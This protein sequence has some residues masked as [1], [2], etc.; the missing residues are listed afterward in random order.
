MEKERRFL[1]LPG[2][3]NS[4][5]NHLCNNTPVGFMEAG[6]PRYHDLFNQLF[7]MPTV[8]CCLLDTQGEK[9]DD[10]KN[11]VTDFP[12]KDRMAAA[13]IVASWKECPDKARLFLAEAKF[14]ITALNVNV[15][16]LKE[17]DRRKIFEIQRRDFQDV[18]TFVMEV[19]DGT[20]K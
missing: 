7:A 16:D 18:T 11:S 3:A 4:L 17:E 13:Y 8:C 15:K 14:P 19:R 10:W 12:T 20:W 6:D 2:I 1:K 5:H 9:V